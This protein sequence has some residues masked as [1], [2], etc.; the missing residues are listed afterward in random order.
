[1]QSYVLGFCFNSV[2]EE[3]VLIRKLKPEFQKF[4]FNGVGSGRMI[5]GRQR[6]HGRFVVFSAS[7]RISKASRRERMNSLYLQ[8]LI[9]S[10]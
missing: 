2:L 10:R 5:L 9:I 7:L 3:V 6:H 4:K 1:M 8:K